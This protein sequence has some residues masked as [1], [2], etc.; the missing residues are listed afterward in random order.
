MNND[1]VQI[2]FE[3]ILDEL[4]SVI[5]DL[6]TELEPNGPFHSLKMV[7]ETGEKLEVF[8]LKV[9]QLRDEWI[10]TFDP[11]TRSRTEFQPTEPSPKPKDTVTLTVKYGAAS[12]RA[13]YLG[14]EVRLLPGSTIKMQSHDSLNAATIERKMEALK[15]GQIT[16][17][18]I[19]ELYEV[20][21]PMLF[22][23]PSAAAY[24]VAGCSVSGP[25]DW[26]VL[27]TGKS[28]KSWMETI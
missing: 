7:C 4:G 10:A 1:G 15:K 28:L 9:S 12:A 18:E 27:G 23:S 20:K 5:N 3:I 2:A 26:Q 13:E 14:N 19:F 16:A 8:Q 21:S 17:S 22:N 24:F 25:R 6:R 11:P